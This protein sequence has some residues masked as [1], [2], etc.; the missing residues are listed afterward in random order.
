[1]TC[2]VAGNLPVAKDNSPHARDRATFSHG[3]GRL[4]LA[5]V[6]MRG[7]RATSPAPIHVPVLEF[8]A[9]RAVHRDNVR[10]AVAASEYPRTCTLGGAVLVFFTVL[11]II[12]TQLLDASKHTPGVYLTYL[13]MAVVLFTG[14]RVL[15]TN[16]VPQRARPWV[17][18]LVGTLMGV[19][20]AVNVAL[21]T[22]PYSYAIYFLLLCIC[23]GAILAWRPYI[24]FAIAVTGIGL[25]T[26]RVWPVGPTI[27]W[28]MLTLGAV[29]VGAVLLNV[30]LR[31]V[32]ELADATAETQHLADSDQLTGLLNRH[33]LMKRIDGLW[34]TAIRLDQSLF[35]VFVDIQ[36][37][38]RANDDHGH[39]FGDKA[40]RSA[41]RAVVKS[42]RAGDLV[43]RWGGDEIV[44]IGMGQMPDAHAF[45]ERLQAQT[46]WTAEDR[47]KWDGELSVG[48]ASGPPAAE[49]VDSI[50]GRADKDMY[51][52]RQAQ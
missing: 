33:G 48:F 41:A 45:N 32:F 44:V 6:D 49:T 21:V 20:L 42:V 25:V 37:L 18:A 47:A 17:F 46:E 16:T 28:L 35:V 9:D 13:C 38:K 36:G 1:M 5:G 39:E 19:G 40:I 12:A 14:G 8:E 4:V 27:N 24:V 50:I 51:R 34:S 22:E 15:N 30:R 26:L 7:T 10:I 23:G 29:A 3:L 31:T 43:A 52:R 2:T 11:T